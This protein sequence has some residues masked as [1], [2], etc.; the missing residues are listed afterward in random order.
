M[1]IKEAREILNLREEELSDEEVQELIDTA[2][3]FK[4]IFFSFL[5]SSKMFRC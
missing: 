2:T 1:T 4:D 5:K 3:L